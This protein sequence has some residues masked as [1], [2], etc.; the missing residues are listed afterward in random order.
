[1]SCRLADLDVFDTGR[2]TK[3][4]INILTN[5]V[6]VGKDVIVECRS[7]STSAPANNPL[8]LAYNLKENGR[9]ALRQP[10]TSSRFRIGSISK[11][12]RG[13]RYSCVATEQNTESGE[14]TG[15]NSVDS[16]EYVMNPQY[17]LGNIELIPPRT[18]YT[19]P[20][21]T[22]VEDI[23]CRAECTPACTYTWQKN[24]Q[25][26]SDRQGVRL[27]RVGAGSSGTYTCVA[28]NGEDSTT[29]S[30]VVDVQYP[31]KDP[32]GRELISP[33]NMLYQVEEG[34]LVLPDIVC[35]ADC[36]PQCTVQVGSY[37]ERVYNGPN[38][39][40]VATQPSFTHFTGRDDTGKYTCTA[41][42]SLGQTTT[43]VE[44]TFTVPSGTLL[45]AVTCSADCK[46]ACSYRWV[47]DDSTDTLAPLAT[48]SL[49]QADPEDAGIYKC[50]ATND[51]G[52]ANAKFDLAVQYT[53]Y[54]LS[55]GDDLSITCSAV[56]DPAC[57]FRWED[58]S[59]I[60]DSTPL[61]S[62]NGILTLNE[63]RRGMDGNYTCEA[64]NIAGSD[65]KAVA[66]EVQS[67]CKP[68][69]TFKWLRGEVEVSTKPVLL[70][71]NIQRNQADNYEYGP[72]EVRMFPDEQQLYPV[73]GSSVSLKCWATC[74]PECTYTWY[75]RGSRELDSTDGELDLK[76]VTT[77][78]TGE[79]TCV[80]SNGIGPPASRD[81][82][83]NVRAGPGTTIRFNPPEDTAVIVEGR[84]LKVEC[85]AECSPACSYTWRKGS[86][87]VAQGATLEFPAGSYSCQASNGIGSASSINVNIDIQSNEAI[88]STNGGLSLVAVGPEN[89][90]T[91]RCAARNGIGLETTAEVALVVQTVE[92]KLYGTLEELRRTAV[93]SK[94]YGTLE[95]LRRTAVESK[96]YGTLEEL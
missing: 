42:N 4:Q 91:Y 29:I 39:E 33:A 46:P 88:N 49:G 6:I 28:S 1:M 8:K 63:V 25:T 74:N 76:N 83:I 24:G 16:D 82:D 56:C 2:P 30:F 48:L 45:P 51:H 58:S 14:L 80:A 52:E 41:S 32:E 40:A 7:T 18:E 68:Q 93:E 90:G 53:N 35:N 55:S 5:P 23:F 12:K 95:E 59:G 31:P 15:L 87:L 89:A 96:L 10:T 54:D 86:T 94:L 61:D 47:K 3:P 50:L 84:R 75:S 71:G 44:S 11:A 78:D 21:G 69:C 19:V 65:T 26:I 38:G 22:Q 37:P 73:R 81:V 27:G 67:D 72:D 13:A 20:E 92:T 57:T 77:S 17:R 36:N 70:L 60:T 66:L 79:Y 43:S 9:L 85:I 34:A 62:S 64:S